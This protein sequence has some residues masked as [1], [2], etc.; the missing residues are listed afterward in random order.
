METEIKLPETVFV[1]DASF[2]EFATLN[3][4]S[5]F[6][7]HLGRTLG[8]IDLSLLFTYLMLDTEISIDDKQVQVLLAY[9]GETENFSVCSPSSLKEEL[10]GVAFKNEELG[11]FLFASTTTE[12]MVSREE[13]FLDLVRVSCENDNVKNIVL[14]TRE[15]EY[16]QELRNLI[17]ENKDKNISQFGITKQPLSTT[18]TYFLF[19]YP[20]MK[21]MGIRGDEL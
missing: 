9:D 12:G 5:F 7:Q 15:D 19:A 10:N 1:V 16:S 14:L 8:E 17:E 6:E 2:L 13:L 4:K 3:L 20:A 18:I 11:E 21:A